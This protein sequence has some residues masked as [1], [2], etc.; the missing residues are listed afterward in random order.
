M[1]NNTSNKDDSLSS[2]IEEVTGEDSIRIEED[3]G[4]GFVRLRS[5]EAERRQAAQDIRS[6]EDAIIELLRN[7]RDA[8]AKNIYVASGK[9][10]NKRTFIVID[11]GCGIP[12]SMRELV[13]QPRVTSKLD[14]AHMDTWGYHGRGMALYSIAENSKE[15]KIVYSSFGNGTSIKILLDEAKVSEKRDQS[16]FPT[17]EINDGV[18]LMRGPKNIQRV[19][20]EFSVENRKELKV[21]L[22]SNT[23]IAAT[24]FSNGLSQVSEKKRIFMKDHCHKNP[25]LMLACSTDP[26]S[27]SEAAYELGLDISSRSARRILDKE[28]APIDALFDQI[29]TSIRQNDELDKSKKASKAKPIASKLEQR[30]NPHISSQDLNEFQN[31]VQHSFSELADK[32][33][34]KNAQAKISI[35]KGKLRL[36]FDL[37]DDKTE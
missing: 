30:N 14:S 20:C 13:F 9:T 11:D 2:F 19:A 21:Y 31:S 27:F 24:L 32:Y 8:G 34:L 10:K 36:D 29:K 15:H 37:L 1:P 16:T 4:Q 7:S 35:R 3:F 6:S 18:F 23:E 33:F 17:C 5:S 28:I 26:D 22:G 25:A 12:E